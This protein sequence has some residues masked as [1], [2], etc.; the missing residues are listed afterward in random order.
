MKKVGEGWKENRTEEEREGR[1]EEK[2]EEGRKR[3]MT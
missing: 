1:K 2:V 3:K